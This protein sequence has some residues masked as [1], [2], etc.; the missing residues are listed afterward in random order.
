MFL[1]HEALTKHALF[2]LPLINASAYREWQ[3][4]QQQ[5]QQQQEQ[6]QQYWQ[7]WRRHHDRRRHHHR[8]HHLYAGSI[9]KTVSSIF[10]RTG[11]PSH[12]H[13]P[14]LQPVWGVFD[15]GVVANAA[16]RTVRA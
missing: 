1:Y 3:Q 11:H 16:E 5:Q 15:D 12:H 13:L 8:R 14:F 6:H 4:Q 9:F 7:Q 10:T 2:T